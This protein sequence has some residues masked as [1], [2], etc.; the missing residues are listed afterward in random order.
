MNPA[1]V[2]SIPSPQERHDDVVLSVVAPV[3]R[4]VRASS[5]GEAVWFERVNKPVWGI[6]VHALGDAAWIAG[7]ARAVLASGLGVGRGDAAFADEDLEDKWTGGLRERDALIRF[8]H[9]DTA[10]CIEALEGERSGALPSRAAYNVLIVERL[11]DALGLTGAP[12]L[13]F[14]RRGF[15][16]ALDLGRWDAEVIE[17][18]ER[19]LPSQRAA[20][21]AAFDP[22]SC[23]GPGY[24]RI[25]RP[26]VAAVREPLAASGIDPSEIAIFAVHAH[27]NRLG[28]NASRGAAL[29]YLAWRARGGGPP[30]TP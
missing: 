19:A 21:E 8:H 13:D 16:W 28:V 17:A 27:S 3:V 2:V 5:R 15:Q 18:L 7:E 24:D 10:A 9:H 22:A 25:V 14:Y 30:P 1:L 29:R 4:A 26:L 11:L 20:L 6:R 23:G 12:R